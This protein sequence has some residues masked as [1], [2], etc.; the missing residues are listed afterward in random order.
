[1]LGLKMCHGRWDPAGVGG[2]DTTKNQTGPPARSSRPGMELV[3]TPPPT[4][5]PGQ[6]ADAYAT[7][8]LKPD[9]TRP[10]IRRAYYRLALES[11]PDRNENATDGA[12][13]QKIKTAYDLLFAY[14]Y[15]QTFDAE[16]EALD[17]E[18]EEQQRE[19]V[20]LERKRQKRED[21]AKAQ[22]EMMDNILRFNQNRREEDA[23]RQQERKKEAEARLRVAQ[24][25]VDTR[26]LKVRDQEAKKTPPKGVMLEWAGHAYNGMAGKMVGNILLLK[27]P[28]A[29]DVWVSVDKKAWIERRRDFWVLRLADGRRFALHT[30]IPYNTAKAQNGGAVKWAD[31]WE[32]LHDRCGHL[33]RAGTASRSIVSRAVDAEE[34]AEIELRE[35]REATKGKEA[36]QKESFMAQLHAEQQR[37]VEERRAREQQRARLEQQRE[38]AKKQKDREQERARRLAEAEEEQIKVRQLEYQDAA[39]K[40]FLQELA[41][42]LAQQ[43]DATKAKGE[44]RWVERVADVQQK[45]ADRKAMR[46]HREEK[47]ASLAKSAAEAR[48]QKAAE[49]AKHSRPMP[50]GAA[51]TDLASAPANVDT[52][53]VGELKRIILAAGMSADDCIEKAGLR[54]RAL[55]AIRTLQSSDGPGSSDTA[56]SGVVAGSSSARATATAGGGDGQPKRPVAQSAAAHSAVAQPA[57]RRKVTICIESEEEDEE[58]AAVRESED[59]DEVSVDLES[60]TAEAEV[61]TE[62]EMAELA[63]EAE[64]AEQ[65]TV[66]V[67]VEAIETQ[68]PGAAEAVSNAEA[69]DAGEASAA[70]VVK[71]EEAAACDAEAPVELEKGLV[72][73]VFWEAMQQWYRGRVASRRSS[74][75]RYK[76]VYDD[77]DKRWMNLDEI[78]WRRVDTCTAVSAAEGTA[79][80]TETDDATA[81]AVAILSQPS[82]PVT[83]SKKRGVKV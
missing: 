83:R 34:L 5:L 6:L 21:D 66:V 23:R 43:K 4:L 11:H 79:A 30:S 29:A 31:W 54:A 28:R 60:E 3:A 32:L 27:H 47:E 42:E 24:Y 67:K 26:A 20:E 71:S 16:L 15:H 81:A 25:Q 53:G 52:L 38:E 61:K 46:Q 78:P 37:E 59:E 76:I 73:E 56:V 69:T 58:E 48:A 1:M 8:K 65:A 12:V 82:K 72:V 50:A 55:E 10:E 13:F 68:A 35:H 77:S 44:E 75:G 41:A 63:E 40:A 80:K 57:V 70:I 64:E 33:C 9:A 2:I 51:A 18:L 19:L 39:W 17:A 7:L 45:Q 62:Q 49:P 14:T 74:T 36:A 22:Q